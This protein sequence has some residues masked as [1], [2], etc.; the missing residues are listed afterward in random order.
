MQGKRS[1][2]SPALGGILEPIVIQSDL[3]LGSAIENE[4]S[5]VS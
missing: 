1:A 2:I 4:L 5:N 3:R